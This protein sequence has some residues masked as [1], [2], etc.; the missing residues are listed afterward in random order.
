M[1]NN[2][3]QAELNVSRRKTVLIAAGGT[4]GH[5]FPALAV[6]QALR[7]K[8]IDVVWL[9]TRKGIESTLVPQ[10]QFYIHYI[11]VVGLRGKNALAWLKAPFLMLFAVMSA[12][13]F[14]IKV[15][16]RCVLG[17]GG[18]ASAAAGVAAFLTFTPLILQEQNAVAGTTNKLLAP[19]AVKIFTGFPNVFQN[20]AKTV[21]SGNPLRTAIFQVAAPE[22]RFNSAV[23]DNK[24]EQASLTVLVLGGSLGASALNQIM[25]AALARLHTEK[26]VENNSGTNSI[27]EL[28]VVHQTGKREVE[29]VSRD[30]QSAGVDAEVSSFIDD[31]AKVYSEAD[32]VVARA[33]ALTVS[34]IAAVGVAALLIPYPHAIDN[35]QSINAD[36]LVEAGAAIK[37]E[38]Q[39]FTGDKAYKLLTTLLTD[40]AGLLKRAKAARSCA[41][42]DATQIIAR[43]CEG[44][45][46]V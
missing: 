39:E 11:N 15:R 23:H 31:M 19:L 9:G 33:G 14:M 21:F 17:M 40:R 28:H 30:Y 43:A 45:A 27:P 32:L 29:Q 26:N 37:V 38:Q 13:A 4:G 44:F 5:V 3:N 42:P 20:Y 8:D 16:P 41:K 25:P 18:F 7:E 2:S 12:I 6:A 22:Q 10:N 24:E 36:W 35:H 34:E 1:S 46:Y